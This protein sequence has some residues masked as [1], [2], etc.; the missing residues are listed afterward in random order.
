MALIF[1]CDSLSTEKFFS[2]SEILTSNVII[3]LIEMFF[4]SFQSIDYY[5][6]CTEPLSKHTEKS[7][8]SL[9]DF[10]CVLPPLFNFSSL[11]I[12][13]TIRCQITVVSMQ[14]NTLCDENIGYCQTPQL[15][16][17]QNLFFCGWPHVMVLA[18]KLTY[19]LDNQQPD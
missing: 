13:D 8:S 16:L 17:I 4:S 14:Y 19:H 15:S 2:V 18:H 1:I 12:F 7:L 6:Q 11:K 3:Q 5:T 10:S 9:L